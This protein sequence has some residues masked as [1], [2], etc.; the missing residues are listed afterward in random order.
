MKA[1]WEEFGVLIKDARTKLGMSQHA[2]AKY[3]DKDATTVSR[4]EKGE[5]HPKQKSLFL[6]SKVLGIRVQ[7]LQSTAG[8][9]PEFDWYA[10]FS[11]KPDS[12][13]DILLSASKEEKEV[14]R[15]YLHYLRFSE[16]VRQSHSRP[17]FEG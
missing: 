3:V 8:Y 5:R 4:W 10:S 9:T 14:L 6:L 16:Q 17:I 15:Q 2:L 12:Q 7:T 11:A 1:Q 13:E